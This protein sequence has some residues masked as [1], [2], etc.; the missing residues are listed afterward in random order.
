MI[1]ALDLL[2]GL[3]DGLNGHMDSLV[4]SSNV[5]ELLFQSMQVIEL[6]RLFKLLNFKKTI[7]KK[8]LG[9]VS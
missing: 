6:I 1:V 9:S 4:A 2:S 5:I 7:F 8:Y 3:A